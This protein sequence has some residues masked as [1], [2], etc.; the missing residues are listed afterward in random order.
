MSRL[1]LLLTILDR[2]T[3][4]QPLDE[5]LNCELHR[6]LHLICFLVQPMKGKFRSRCST[7]HHFYLETIEFFLNFQFT[8]LPTAI[9]A[10]V[11]YLKVM[12]QS[13]H[14]QLYPTKSSEKCA[15]L[16]KVGKES[17]L[18]RYTDL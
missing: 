8:C 3:F 18:H 16:K 7:L 12:K 4:L 5:L 9:F 11:K 15:C 14:N 10:K 13:I 17:N 2:F 6:R 1:L